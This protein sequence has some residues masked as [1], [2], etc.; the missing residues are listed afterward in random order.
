MQA[1][2]IDPR[3]RRTRTAGPVVSGDSVTTVGTF[4][5]G[6]AAHGRFHVAAEAEVGSFASGHPADASDLTAA[7][8]DRDGAA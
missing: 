8:Q 3:E 1:H 6:Q 4:A 5:A 2:M 7:R